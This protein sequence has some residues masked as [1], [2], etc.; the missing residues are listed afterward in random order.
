MALAASYRLPDALEQ[1]N[2]T[3]T[4]TFRPRRRAGALDEVPAEPGSAALFYL[5]NSVP[6]RQGATYAYQIDAMLISQRVGIP[7]INGYSGWGAAGLGGSQIPRLG[8]SYLNSA[9]RWLG[10]GTG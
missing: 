1:V 4:A 3:P 6:D 2:V 5:A 8:N 7:T 9:D 10:N